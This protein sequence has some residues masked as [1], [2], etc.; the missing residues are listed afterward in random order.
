[1]VT[2]PDPCVLALVSIPVY[3]NINAPSTRSCHLESL[4][5]YH[6][7]QLLELPRSNQIVC[8]ECQ[9][10]CDPPCDCGNYESRERKRRSVQVVQLTETQIKNI[11]ET[12][13]VNKVL[14]E[15]KPKLD[16]KTSCGL[17]IFSGKFDLNKYNTFAL[18]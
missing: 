18:V 5:L 3:R 7:Y 9:A 11:K 14:Q 17:Q 8:F 4:Y 12:G 16:S 1:M 10:D 6:C 2:P 15:A 13:S